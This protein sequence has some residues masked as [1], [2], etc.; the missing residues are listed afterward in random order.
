MTLEEARKKVVVLTGDITLPNLGLGKADLARVQAEVDHVI[1][2]AADIG[3]QREVAASIA[4][5]Y[6]V[7]SHPFPLCFLVTKPFRPVFRGHSSLW[8]IVEGCLL[9]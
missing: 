8:K 2:A 6:E 5:N 3:F 1:H 9:T 4:H 7:R